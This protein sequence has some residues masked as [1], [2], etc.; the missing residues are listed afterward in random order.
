[1]PTTIAAAADPLT[2]QYKITFMICAENEACSG[3]AK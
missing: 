3:I 1:M 2:E